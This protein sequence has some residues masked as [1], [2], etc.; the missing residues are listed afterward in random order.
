MGQGRAGGWDGLPIEVNLF[1]SAPGA[2]R[3]LLRDNISGSL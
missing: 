2:V 1:K 3:D